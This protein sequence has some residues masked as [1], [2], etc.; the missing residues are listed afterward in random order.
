M[1][2]STTEEKARFSFE[3]DTKD[4]SIEIVKDDGV[5]RHIDFTKNGSSCY[6]V[7][8]TTWPGYLCIS[9]DMGCHTFQR[10]ND[11]F[12]FFEQ[13][14]GINPLYWSQ[15]LQKPCSCQCHKEFDEDEFKRKIKSDFDIHWENLEDDFEGDELEEKLQ[16]KS[17]CW[18]AIEEDILSVLYDGENA[19]FSAVC[20]FEC[21]GFDFEDFH[22]TGCHEYTHHYLWCLYAIVKVIDLYNE[23]KEKD[24]VE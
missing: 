4:H 15:K 24:D 7:S 22:F 1:M 19:L 2:L 11:M 8:I 17:E 10:D 5:F 13:H 9:G 16:E 23:T 3:K 12:E 21:H 20:Q 6:G 14:E 18:S